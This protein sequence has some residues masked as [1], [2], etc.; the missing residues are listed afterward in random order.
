MMGIWVCFLAVVS[1]TA[2]DSAVQLERQE[3]HSVPDWTRPPLPW[4]F[5]AEGEWALRSGA[6]PVVKEPLPPEVAASIHNAAE[7]CYRAYIQANEAGGGYLP[8][9]RLY[10]P[11]FRLEAPDT[12]N[13]YAFTLYDRGHCTE[14]EKWFYFLLFDPQSR[15]VTRNCPCAHAK[16]IKSSLSCGP[17]V[18]FF[19]V[20]LDGRTELV[21]QEIVHNGTMYHA[22][23]YYYYRVTADM[24]LLPLFALEARV[25]DLYSHERGLIVRTLER[26]GSNRLRI[27]VALENPV[28]T[29]HH[30]E[31]GT[32]ILEAKD[33]TS[34]FEVVERNVQ[35]SRYAG[36]LLTASGRA[37]QAFLK[38]GYRAGW[39]QEKGTDGGPEH[40]R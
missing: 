31:L 6:L 2:A 15:K 21:V 14:S 24:D 5:V 7:N 28:G 12:P 30:Q 3:C 36:C 13:L 32:T 11:V 16:H 26:L 40:G 19:D 37:E 25:A 1:T 4:A 34:P 27:D 18:H 39:D 33:G 23:I 20:N 9:A 10:G 38:D 8:M 17:L 35:I 22:A 29:P